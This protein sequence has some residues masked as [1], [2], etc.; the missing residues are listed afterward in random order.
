MKASKCS[1]TSSSRDNFRSPRVQWVINQVAEHL[2]K[3]SVLDIGFV[4]SYNEPF[5]HLM[6]REL[7][8]NYLYGVDIDVEGVLKNRLKHTFTA[9]GY[10]LPF[11]AGSFKVVLLLEILEHLTKPRSM[12][13]EA[14]RIL[15]SDGSLL[16]TTPNAFA[17]WN[18]VR[19][20]MMGR[21]T[22]R[23]RRDV[24]KGF[25]GAP[26]H[27]QFFDPLSLMNLL[28]DCGFYPI[29]IETRNHRVPFFSR[30]FRSLQLLDLRFWPADRLGHY[31]CVVAKPRI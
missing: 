26:D 21:L 11:K 12:L 5:L 9:D 20:W 1:D 10:C 6:L 27:K 16:L 24:Y 25:L 17:W 30:Y 8:P 22:T 2:P 31:I 13:F 18:V 23:V 3:G 28:D 29:S 4:G 14:K 19:W 15:S 7:R